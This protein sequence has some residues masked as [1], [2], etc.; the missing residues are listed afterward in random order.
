MGTSHFGVG[1]AAFSTAS[2]REGLIFDRV[3]HG[4]VLPSALTGGLDQLTCSL[5]ENKMVTVT[6]ES[7]WAEGSF[8]GYALV[9]YVH[10]NVWMK[11]LLHVEYAP[12]RL[13][14]TQELTLGQ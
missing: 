14:E 9:K 4:L 13:P 6:Y 1:S 5:P 2:G 11:L 10:N 3:S 12:Y 7:R 8:R